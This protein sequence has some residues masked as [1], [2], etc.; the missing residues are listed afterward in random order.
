MDDDTRL[1]PDP[2]FHREVYRELGDQVR[3]IN[4]L[5]NTYRSVAV[6]G[7]AAVLGIAAQRDAIDWVAWA[8]VGG[9][10]G[11]GFVFTLITN[12]YIQ[13]PL[14]RQRQIMVAV[15]S[16]WWL[17]TLGIT[18]TRST[19]FWKKRLDWFDVIVFGVVSVASMILAII[20]VLL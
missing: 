19:S 14:R 6:I 17:D 12:E 16:A 5:R 2:E 8:I 7:T 13:K 15:W 20:D 11:I 10:S 4:N 9:I 1:A 3:N 18:Q